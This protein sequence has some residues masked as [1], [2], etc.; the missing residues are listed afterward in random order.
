M[1]T[2]MIIRMQIHTS[3]S[4]FGRQCCLASID[5]TV[6]GTIIIMSIQMH[7]SLTHENDDYDG[8]LLRRYECVCVCVIL[9]PLGD[10]IRTFNRL[11]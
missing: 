4:T 10:S 3:S 8:K 6:P 5:E 11:Q 9:G 7:H 2:L 1:I